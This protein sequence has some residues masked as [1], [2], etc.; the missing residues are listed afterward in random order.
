MGAEKTF[1]KTKIVFM[2]EIISN[3]GIIDLM[4]R[5]YQKSCANI[6]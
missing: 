2:I 4:K 3:L 1:N 5:I 6:I